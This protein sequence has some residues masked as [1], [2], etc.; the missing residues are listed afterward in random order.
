[1]S[2][3]RMVFT[4]AIFAALWTGNVATA[5][6]TLN[7]TQDEI[8]VIQVG[9]VYGGLMLLTAGDYLGRLRNGG[10]A[11][12]FDYW[13]G[14][15]TTALVDGVEATLTNVYYVLDEITYNCDCPDPEGRYAFVRSSD[16]R[17]HLRV[18][19]LFLESTDPVGELGAT[20]VHE[21]SHMFG[22]QDC[23]NPIP[24]CGPD[25]P[26]PFSPELAHE[27]AQRD[28]V[29]ATRNAYNLERFVT[30]VGRPR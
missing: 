19:P 4:S 16:P 17:F 3:G 7:C 26:V 23:M 2:M 8:A 20:V 29:T 1:M 10:P 9:Q 14:D 24:L 6:S 30:D 15:H 18:C 27:F 25:D 11:D 12:R 5:Q 13:F 28:P 21:L 22:T